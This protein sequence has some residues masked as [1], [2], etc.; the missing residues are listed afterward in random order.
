[1]PFV[2]VTSD[3]TVSEPNLR[4]LGQ[5]LPDVVAE[6]VE[7]PEEPVVGPAEDGDLEI[8]FR[9][10]GT[11]DLGAL[12]VVIEVRTK[13]YESRIVDQ[14]RRADLILDRLST[15]GLGKIGV[16]LILADGAWS[17]AV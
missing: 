13:R 10:K 15:L 8:R 1:M 17:Q 4:R 5:L 9:R 7:C 14:Q 2:D 3:D 12:N 6:A 11:L 16:W